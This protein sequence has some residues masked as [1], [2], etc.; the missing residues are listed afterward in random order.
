MSSAHVF[1][2]GYVFKLGHAF[3]V[4]HANIFQVDHEEVVFSLN[5]IYCPSNHFHVFRLLVNEIMQNDKYLN[6]LI[7]ITLRR[8]STPIKQY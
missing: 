7:Q 8:L 6:N 2:V 3:K 4:G 5:L 1:K